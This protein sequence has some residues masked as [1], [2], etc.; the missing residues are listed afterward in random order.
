M[1]NI[2]G[3]T[4][5]LALSLS[6]LASAEVIIA[7]PS[8]FAAGADVTHA[9]EGADLYTS[10]IDSAGV[11]SY[12]SVTVTDCNGCRP[13]VDGARVFAQAD[14]RNRFDYE[15]SFA[16]RLRNLST[17]GSEGNVLL[18]DFD[19][20]TNFVQIVGSQGNGFTSF[21]VDIWDDA[22]NWLGNCANG[23]A[24]G[25]CS[26][27]ILSVPSGGTES[28][29]YLPIWELN[30]ISD[31]ANIGFITVAGNSGPGYVKSVGYSIPEPASAALLALG[32]AGLLLGR[33]KIST[34][35]A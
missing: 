7:D 34:S 2:R 14:G 33:R 23:Q 8:A 31:I 25:N 20:Q 15:A 12:D 28:Q 4:V 13:A 26:S 18:V 6:G 32:F 1:L 24:T 19:N 30:F 21:M 35:R 22:G 9:Y 16:Y 27:K 10:H 11:V 17:S 3:I 29:G 5:A